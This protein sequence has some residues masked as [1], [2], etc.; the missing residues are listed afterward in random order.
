[1]HGSVDTI[2]RANVVFVDEDV[3]EAPKLSGLVEQMLSQLAIAT[4]QVVEKLS[5]VRALELDRILMI[6][7]R[8]KRRWMRTFTGMALLL[9][10]F[11]FEKLF[12]IVR[13]HER[14]HRFGLRV[15]DRQDHVREKRERMLEV[16]CRGIGGWSGWE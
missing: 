14:A 16:V 12:S 4:R 15:L 5:D 9:L 7:K 11:L 6:G 3:H 10:H 13:E 2:E 1:M 8:P